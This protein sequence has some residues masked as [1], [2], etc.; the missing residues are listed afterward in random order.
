MTEAYTYTPLERVYWDAKV[1]EALLKEVDLLDL[2]KV[3]IVASSTLSNKT[4]EISKIQEVLGKKFVGLF[5]RCLEHSPLENVIECVNEVKKVNPDIILTIG[6]GTPIDTVK[7]VQLCIAKGIKTI[8]ELKSIT[9]K[10]HNLNSSIRQIAVP[11]TLSGGEYSI[12]GGA[13]DTKKKLKEGYFGSDICPKVV[14]LDPH[15][16]THT[17]DWLWLSTAI[18]SV[19]HAVEGFCSISENPLIAH[20]ALQSLEMFSVS[21]RRTYANRND[22]EARSISQ[23]AVWMVAKNM[24]NVLF[25]ASHGIGYL[26]GSIGSVPHGQTSCVMLPAVLKWN[27]DFQPEKHKIISKALGRPKLKAHEAIRELI[28]D[29]GLPNTLEDVGIKKDMYKKIVDYALNHQIVLS[30]PKPIEKPEDVY[31]ILEYAEKG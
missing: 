22:T 19:D 30:N 1:E 18:R 31:E 13:M 2:K 12:I 8:E 7:V 27:E 29:L 20:N 23:K 6:G 28:T 4:K 24:G 21:L 15:I 16:A 11:T 9:G 3:F 26:L 10:Q 14:I 5:D 25:G 17:P